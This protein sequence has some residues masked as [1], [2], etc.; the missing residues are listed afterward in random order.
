MALFLKR[1][2]DRFIRI[3]GTPREISLGFALGLFIGFS[4][5]MGFQIAMGVLAAALLKCSKIAA[6]IG[7]QVTNPL[8]AP[9]IYSLTY[10]IGAGITGLEKPFVWTGALDLDTLVDMLEKA[11]GILLA[12]TVGGVIIGSPIAVAGYFISHGAVNRYQERIR[13]RL[14]AQRDKIKY[15]MRLRKTRKNRNKDRR[16]K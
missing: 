5:T 8:T 15:I 11:P 16:K 2:Y 1:I 13:E 3:R 4:P 7:V 10:V 9:F 6:A 14:E 12:L